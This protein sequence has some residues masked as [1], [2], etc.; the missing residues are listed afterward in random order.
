MRR[1][2][3]GFLFFHIALV[4]SQ[5]TKLPYPMIEVDSL[6]REDQFYFAFTYNTLA[7]VPTGIRTN[8]FS[9]GFKA[10]VLRDMP[11]N[12]E[13]NVSIATGLG[14]SYSNYF[15]KLFIFR[16]NGEAIYSTNTI[17]TSYSKN[18]FEQVFIDVPIEFRWRTSVPETH[19]FWRIYTGLQLSYLAY[20]KSSYV[21][22]IAEI[23]VSNNKDFNKFQAGVYLVVG[24]NTWNFYSYYG[25]VPI[26]S[27]AARVNDE[28]I[29]MN[30][31][32]FGMMFYIL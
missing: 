30:A 4:F 27:S 7:N 12:K 23:S 6:Y 19:K 1:F 26:F 13:R 11:L 24:Y 5:E 29:T 25:L 21:D 9:A 32:H 18:K 10:G 14:L 16:E 31:L 17:G 22:E 15:Q 3:I 20:S 2:T 28:R 8:K